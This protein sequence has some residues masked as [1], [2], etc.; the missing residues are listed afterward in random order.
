MTLIIKIET[1]IIVPMKHFNSIYHALLI[2]IYGPN[3]VKE[4]NIMQILSK[5]LKFL[6]GFIYI[7]DVDA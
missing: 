4:N 7:H 6:Y 3:P 1:L 2:H 5:Y